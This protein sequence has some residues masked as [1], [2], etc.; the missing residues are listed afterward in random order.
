MIE[1][2]ALAP[3]LPATDMARRIASKGTDFAVALIGIGIPDGNLAEQQPTGLQDDADPGNGLPD[4]S[5]DSD[6]TLGWLS[7]ILAAPAVVVASPEQSAVVTPSRGMAAE[8]SLTTRAPPTLIAL[9]DAMR[10]TTTKAQPQVPDLP[11]VTEVPLREGATTLPMPSSPTAMPLIEIINSPPPARR[12]GPAMIMALPDG[13]P[14][15]V[16]PTLEVVAQPATQTSVTPALPVAIADTAQ[17]SQSSATSS[18]QTNPAHLRDAALSMP[19]LLG[20]AQEPGQ[21]A[22]LSPPA[23]RVVAAA[24][25]EVSGRKTVGLGAPDGQTQPVP[26]VAQPH[27][28]TQATPDVQ[29]T[30]LDLRHNH[31][32]ERMIERIEGL[33]DAADALDTRIRLVPDA[34]GTIDIGLRREGEVVHVHFA[35]E[36]AAT[37]RLLHDAQPRLGELAEARGWKL[38]SST[39]DASGSSGQEQRPLWRAPDKPTGNARITPT[40]TLTP[41]TRIA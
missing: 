35:A 1:L 10:A 37:T 26:Q 12:P 11:G 41:D 19:M 13:P 9:S 3:R 40:A 29:Q 6:A 8:T 33:R 21:V 5:T 15:L 25:Q 18:Q 38:G 23:E 32:P 36:Q 17:E 20:E 24:Q 7:T 39:A 14:V 30:P 4:E 27:H 28:A 22:P 31:W 2:P 34:L 16:A